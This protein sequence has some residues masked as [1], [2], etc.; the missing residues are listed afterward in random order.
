MTEEP[1]RIPPRCLHLPRSGGMAVPYITPQSTAVTFLGLPGVAARAAAVFGAADNQRRTLV[2]L[3]RRCQVCSQPLE[4][5]AI[6]LVRPVDR[7]N[8][9]T[10]EPALHESCFRYSHAVCP[11]LAGRTDHHR[12]TPANLRRLA[13]PGLQGSVT[14]RTVVGDYEPGRPADAFDAWWVPLTQYQLRLDRDSGLDGVDPTRTEH[15]RDAAAPDA[16]GGAY[17]FYDAFRSLLADPEPPCPVSR[18]AST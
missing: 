16:L 7:L 14:A 1:I 18:P 8:G 11:M 2:L 4:R 17:R 9:W 13:P 5:T 6:Y 10:A 3:Q 15:V 12:R